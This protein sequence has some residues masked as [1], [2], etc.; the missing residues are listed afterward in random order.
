MGNA[1][2]N[3]VGT[4]RARCRACHGSWTDAD[5]STH[6]CDCTAGLDSVCGSCNP[7]WKTNIPGTYDAAYNAWVKANPRPAPIVQ[8][9]P[10]AIGNVS[11]ACV[12]CT[13]CQDFSGIKFTDVGSANI[14]N[15]S[16]LQTCIGNM[17]TALTAEEARRAIEVA[18]AQQAA[19]QSA[20]A[21]AQ[22]A[23]LD[24]YAATLAAQQAAALAKQ[25]A[26][27]ASLY[28]AQQAQINALA[29]QAAYQ[30][31]QAAADAEVAA[32]QAAFDS[33]EQIKLG[34]V[35]FLFIVLVFICVLA[36]GVMG[37]LSGESGGPASGTGGSY[38]SRRASPWSAKRYTT[39]TT[40]D[41]PSLLR[42]DLPAT[43][44]KAQ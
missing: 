13:Q 41:D 15:V 5:N 17:Q 35:A 20:Q 12:E 39:T 40:N 4:L 1:N 18:Q 14:S 7:V 34:V 9:A 2:C 25:Q 36:S 29:K 27:A 8:P 3:S 32:Q 31:A 11:I 10:T 43:K 16:Q 28:A 22:K 21:A 26:T 30:K 24:A 33:Q 44:L 37:G 23:Q 38:G 6:S 42:G 19:Q